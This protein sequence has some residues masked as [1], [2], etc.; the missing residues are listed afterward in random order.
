MTQKRKAELFE[1][2]WLAYP[3]KKNRGQAE[4][5]WAKIPLDEE[6]AGLII[7]KVDEARASPE[8]T[9][10]NGR[11]I[12]YPATWLNAKGWEDEIT[13]AEIDELEAWANE[14]AAN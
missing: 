6:L 3:K 10:E 14:Q 8:W 1:L 2:L 13:P 11:F 4:R 5:A 7:S 12:P 9:K